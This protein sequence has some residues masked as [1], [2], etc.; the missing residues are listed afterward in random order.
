MKFLGKISSNSPTNLLGANVCKTCIYMMSMLITSNKQS[1]FK[2][3][4][5]CM[6]MFSTNQFFIIIQCFEC[7]TTLIVKELPYNK[8]SNFLLLF[9]KVP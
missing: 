4:G 2:R 1:L 3:Y 5:A 8:K 9:Q 7:Y 6:T